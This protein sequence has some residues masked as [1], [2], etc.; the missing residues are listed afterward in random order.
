MSAY[1]SDVD[2]TPT[3]VVV[4]NVPFLKIFAND[5]PTKVD[6]LMKRISL[7]DLNNFID[8]PRVAG[9]SRCP[10][11]PLSPT[12]TLPRSFFPYTYTHTYA[13]H[14]HLVFRLEILFA[15]SGFSFI[16]PGKLDR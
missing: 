8:L 5:I 15:L 4:P 12:S 2:V 1:L 7:N 11:R 16:E 10:N 14:A 6:R 13:H 9:T 3:L